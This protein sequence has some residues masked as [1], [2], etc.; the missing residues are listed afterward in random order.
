MAG[1]RIPASTYRL[2]FNREFRFAEAAALVP[3]LD[4][5]GVTDLYASPLYTAR[6]GSPHGYDVADPGR[7]NPELGGEDGFKALAGALR[8]CG[9]GLLLDIVPNHMAAS[10]EN[11][12]W[13][14]VLRNGRDSAYAAYFDIDW[15]PDRP[16]PAGKIL[17]PILGKPYGAVLEDGELTLSMAEDGFTLCYFDK[18]LPLSPRS[19]LEILRYLLGAKDAPTAS[20]QAERPAAGSAPA[21]SDSA[22]GIP[23]PVL[24]NAHNLDGGS[25]GWRDV[26]YGIPYAAHP[27]APPDELSGVLRKLLDSVEKPASAGGPDQVW[28]SFRRYYIISPAVKAFA[29]GKLE[30][31]NGRKGDPRSFDLLGRILDEQAYR[32]A[33][34]KLA[35]E[36]IN[37]RRFFDVSDLVSVRVEEREVF[38][39]THPL[40]FR[41]AETG[42]ATGLRVDHIDGLHDPETYLRRLQDCLAGAGEELFYV[43]AEKILGSGEELPAG[44]P[45]YGTTGYEFLNTLNALFVDGR[46]AGKL[47]SLYSRLS[48]IKPDFDN[49]VYEQKKKV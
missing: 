36:E 13:R 40:V 37:Y 29:D 47:D 10:P 16:G 22:A 19:S 24:S 6:R 48:G 11:P 45:V 7:L 5:L 30:I 15:Q 3:Y 28:Q 38:G 27:A 39:A 21:R 43:V 42:R 32:L 46:G 8:Q 33:F 20:A 26:M 4:A 31:L 41:L 14:D 44:W 25:S 23:Y 34:W 49:V 18:R 2:Q 12:W 1:P 17:L 9:M 35:N